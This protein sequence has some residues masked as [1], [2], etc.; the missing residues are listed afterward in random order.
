MT[1]AQATRVHEDNLKLDLVELA[2]NSNNP[3]KRATAY[4]REKW[5]KCNHGS[6]GGEDMYLALEKYASSSKSLIKMDIDGDWFCIALVTPFM[7]R[8]HK[9]LKE[10]GEVVFVDTT[11]HVDQVNTAITPLLCAGPAGAS[12]LGVIFSSSQDER[13]YESGK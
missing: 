13:S 12:P 3:S 9:S 2:N 11:S 6:V 1:T 7:I 5:L 10:A 4:L 8:I